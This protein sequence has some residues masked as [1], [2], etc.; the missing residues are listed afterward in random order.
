MR[1][2]AR[3]V[4][5]LVSLVILGTRHSQT[6]DVWGKRAMETGSA[7]PKHN[8]QTDHLDGQMKAGPSLHECPPVGSEVKLHEPVARKP[9]NKRSS[10]PLGRMDDGHTQTGTITGAHQPNEANQGTHD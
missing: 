6:S 5:F 3:P 2:G 10:P 9:T 1:P 7:S 8:V 4:S